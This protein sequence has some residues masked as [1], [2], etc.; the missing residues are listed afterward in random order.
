[1]PAISLIRIQ[2]LTQVFSLRVWTLGCGSLIHPC[3]PNFDGRK[4]NHFLAI[5]QIRFQVVG[6]V[7]KKEDPGHTHTYKGESAA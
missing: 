3:E 7:Q 1:M 5:I 4:E 2:L 6:F